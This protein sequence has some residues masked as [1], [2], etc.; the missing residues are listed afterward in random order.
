M[1]AGQQVERLMVFRRERPD[2]GQ[3]LYGIVVQITLHAHPPKVHQGGHVL[4]R[5]L[6]SAHQQRYGFV[7]VVLA[8]GGYGGAVQRSHAARP[9]LQGFV[10]ARRGRRESFHRQFRR[11]ALLPVAG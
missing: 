8:L 3:G 11:P 7:Q 2:A 9:D 5:R 4:R 6:P 1:C 10:E